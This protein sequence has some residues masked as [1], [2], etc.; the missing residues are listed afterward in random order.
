MRGLPW[1]SLELPLVVLERECD[2]LSTRCRPHHHEIWGNPP[3]GTKSFRSF[4]MS[5]FGR[6]ERRRVL[7]GVI[8]HS[9]QSCMQHGAAFLRLCLLSSVGCPLAVCGWL[10][11]LHQA[12]RKGCCSPASPRPARDEDSFLPGLL[13]LQAG[14]SIFWCG[15]MGLIARAEHQA[16]ECASHRGR[17]LL[18]FPIMCGGYLAA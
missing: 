15:I 6:E 18:C 8:R 4:L 3:C 13:G 5:L 1:H 11:A 9:R 12:I 16:Y 14:L 7:L 2:L 17:S 10:G